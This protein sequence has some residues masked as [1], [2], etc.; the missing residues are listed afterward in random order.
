MQHV[1]VLDQVLPALHAQASGLA[2][3]SLRTVLHIVVVADHLSANEALLKVA[4]DHARGLRR[5]ASARNRPRPNLL[6]ARREV[7]LQLEQVVGL[8]NQAVHARLLKAQVVE[9]HAAFLIGFELGDVGFGRGGQVQH[10]RALFGGH[11][12][13]LFNPVVAGLCR[14]LFNVAHVHHGLVGQ[15]LVVVDP[16]GLFFGSVKA[17]HR[18]SLLEV[19]FEALA[20]FYLAHR[21]TGS[22]L[23]GLARAVQALLEGFEVLELQL[24]INRFLVAERIH[25][26]VDVNNV[27]VF[28]AAQ[29][30]Q[31]R[32]ALANVAQKLVA[33]ALALARALHQAGDVDD[34]DRGRLHP[35]GV[36]D[37]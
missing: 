25:A 6:N 14:G 7:G 27:V 23:G 18:L 33:E 22:A 4:V 8:A 3:G 1:A 16:C 20:H 26:T 36:D 29:H 10:A 24:K 34:F 5:R 28:K 19:L 15:Q 30:V 35:L 21:L 37:F 17:A 13:H 9:E 2:A 32:V 11:G 31:N 12:A